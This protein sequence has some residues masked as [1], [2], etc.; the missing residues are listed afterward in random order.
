M[1][2]YQNEQ[3]HQKFFVF[4]VVL[5]FSVVEALYISTFFKESVLENSAMKTQE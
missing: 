3:F 5:N 4:F 2:D 1:Q